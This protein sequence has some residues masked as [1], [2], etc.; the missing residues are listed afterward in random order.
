MKYQGIKF[1]FFSRMSDSLVSVE[2]GSFHLFGRIV[3][4]T[5]NAFLINHAPEKLIQF[6]AIYLYLKARDS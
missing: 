3:G 2:L 4:N 1:L 5:G 6:N